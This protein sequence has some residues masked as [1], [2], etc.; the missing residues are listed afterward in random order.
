MP[1]AGL[2][3]LA[4]IAFDVDP[5]ARRVVVGHLRPG[6]NHVQRAITVLDVGIAGP[7]VFVGA[8]AGKSHGN[9]HGRTSKE[10]KGICEIATLAGVSQRTFSGIEFSACRTCRANSPAAASSSVEWV[11]MVCVTSST[12]WS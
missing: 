3:V 10:C 12:R 2:P 1:E 5:L 8:A 11:S 4:L 9:C 6:T 7:H